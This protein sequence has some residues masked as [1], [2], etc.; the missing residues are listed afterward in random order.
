MVQRGSGYQPTTRGQSLSWQGRVIGIGDPFHNFGAEAYLFSK[1]TISSGRQQSSEFPD[2]STYSRTWAYRSPSVNRHLIDF[3][4][5]NSRP[6]P[7]DNAKS[8]AKPTTEYPAGAGFAG[9]LCLVYHDYRTCGRRWPCGG[10][11]QVSTRAASLSSGRRVFLLWERHLVARPAQSRQNAAPPMRGFR[12]DTGSSPSGGINH[13]NDKEEN[14]KKPFGV[15]VFSCFRDSF[16]HQNATIPDQNLM[17]TRGQ[18]S[19]LPSFAG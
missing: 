12:M 19:S 13:E 2:A 8:G 18:G 4:P 15:F 16:I 3:R 10:W 6:V 14:R 1:V 5:K 17:T 9:K 11:R 7:T